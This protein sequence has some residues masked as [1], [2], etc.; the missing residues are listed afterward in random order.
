MHIDTDFDFRTDAR[1][2]DPDKA[3]RA[4]RTHHRLLWSK[5]LPCG[6]LFDLSDVK[7]GR[8]LHHVSDL[9]EFTL[10]SDSVL[11]TYVG[12]KAMQSLLAEFSEQNLADFVRLTYTI[13]GMLVFPA[14]KV[15]GKMTINGARG[16]SARLADRFDLTLECIRRHYAGQASP[17]DETLARYAD[18]FA[19]FGDFAGY[20]DFFL[21]QDLLTADGAVG[22]FLPF[23]DFASKPKP[24]NAK[25]YQHFR[26]ATS[27]F[28]IARNRRIADY[29]S[30]H[31]NNA[32]A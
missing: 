23:D 32:A 30:Q 17:L 10:A 4:L 31:L 24:D 18:F 2:Q 5:P 9:G 19:L 15:G 29:A 14:N 1:G 27:A 16:C 11:P 21:L 26:E 12:H 13:G 20:C 8:Y 7:P 22:F 28:V 6:R 25:A 3:S